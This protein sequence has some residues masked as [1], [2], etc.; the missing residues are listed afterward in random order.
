MAKRKRCAGSHMVV[1]L[2][3]N[4]SS[5]TDWKGDPGTYAGGAV[6]PKCSLGMEVLRG[7]VREIEFLRTGGNP[8][9][10]MDWWPGYRGK[11]RMHWAE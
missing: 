11:L 4:P 6:C 3:W 1:R 7:S 10:P 5:T 8:D 9:D 2:D